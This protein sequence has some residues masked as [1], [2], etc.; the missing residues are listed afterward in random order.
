[1]F[2]MDNHK[3]LTISSKHSFNNLPKWFQEARTINA[4]VSFEDSILQWE[5]GVWNNG[6]WV[7]GL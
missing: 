5:R 4:V 6:T 1:M 7:N 2:H 3:N